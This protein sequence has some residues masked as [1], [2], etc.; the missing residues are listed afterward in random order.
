MAAVRIGVIGVGIMGS[1][2]ARRLKNTIKGAELVAVADIAKEKVDSL[3]KELSCKALYQPNDLLDPALVDAVIIATPHYSH[4]DLTITALEKGLHVLVE[5]PMAVQKSEAER[6]LKAHTNPKQIFSVMLNQ[7][8]VTLHKRLKALIDE[9]HLGTIRRI[10]WIIT[11]WYRTQSYYNQ[12]GWRATWGGEGGGVL[13]NQVPHNLDLLLWFFGKPKSVQAFCHF[14]KFHD[15]EVED[16]VTAYLEY[17]NGA[18]GVFIASTGEA[19]GTNRLEISAD[20]GKVVLENGK[21]QFHRN[22]TSAQDFLK[23]SKELFAK[24]E[25]WNCELPVS[26]KVDAQHDLLTQN[27]IDAINNGSPLIAPAQEAIGQVELANA[28]LY[29]QLKGSKIDLPLNGA[30]FAKE[31]DTLIAGSKFKRN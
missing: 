12:G 4:P 3:S 23:N 10:N 11:D 14:G 30:S 16:E 24:P 21:L 31:L 6:M 28:M 18:T 29:S 25:V 13:V 15:I 2:H 7:R 27:F 19:P 5:K 1:G 20:M 8:T 9:G 26:N 22:V 17:P